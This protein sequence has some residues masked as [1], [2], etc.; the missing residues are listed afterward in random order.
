APDLYRNSALGLYEGE[1]EPGHRDNTLSSEGEDQFDDEDAEMDDLDEGA[2]LGIRR[3]TDTSEGD[4]DDND[5]EDDEDGDNDEDDEDE[6]YED[7]HDHDHDDHDVHNADLEIEIADRVGGSIGLPEAL[8]HSNTMDEA[9]RK[10]MS[11]L[12][13]GPPDLG[14]QAGTSQILQAARE[15][16]DI[17]D[18]LE[19]DEGV[20]IA[21]QPNAV[22]DVFEGGSIDFGDDV[23][24]DHSGGENRAEAAPWSWN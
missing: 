17:E 22:D 10:L 15:G 14:L 7:D 20:S 5:D 4:H 19:D 2:M 11:F 6:D 23:V 3:D 12:N 18:A 8:G 16:A 24:V 1:L 9:T 21:D 13:S